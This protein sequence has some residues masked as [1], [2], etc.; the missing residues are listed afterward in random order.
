MTETLGT[1]PPDQSSTDNRSPWVAS[2]LIT[3]LTAVVVAFLIRTHTPYL[4]GPDYWRWPWRLIDFERIVAAMGVVMVPFVIAQFQYR[5]RRRP[6]GVNLVLLM[7]SAFGLMMMGSAVQDKPASLTRIHRIVQDTSVT[8]YYTE[9]ERHLGRPDL[10]RDYPELISN[11]HTHARNKPPGQVLYYTAF[12]RLERA[13]LFGSSPNAAAFI[14]GVFLA[15]LATLA[16]PCT[17]LLARALGATRDV[18]FGAASLMSI[19]PGYILFFPGFDQLWPVLACLL[20]ALWVLAMTRKR[21]A[22]AVL[23]GLVLSVALLFSYLLLVLG[24]FIAIWTAIYVFASEDRGGLQAFV[25]Y[26]IVSL[27]TLVLVYVLLHLTTGYNAIAM[28]QS[29]MGSHDTL[30]T[31]QARPYW[32]PFFWDHWDFVIGSGWVASMLTLMAILRGVSGTRDLQYWLILLVVLQIAIMPVF[33]VFRGETARLLIFLMPLIAFTGAQELAKWPFA[34][35][36]A[37]FAAAGMILVTVN[38]NLTY[39]EFAP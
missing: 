5:R 14:G 36:M 6:L 34:A 20:I 8:G 1:P 9:A 27:G 25:K 17:Y 26:T 18:G 15:L 29:V 12:L 33:G 4:N 16:V 39:I 13:G 32:P 19:M 35:R 3:L 21:T 28:F 38:Q 22:F 37:A 10:L 2:A 30:L 11:M 7:A 23:F 24:L 31:S